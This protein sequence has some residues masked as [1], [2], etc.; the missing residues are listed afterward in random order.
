MLDL[1]QPRAARSKVLTMDK[2]IDL[3]LRARNI[4]PVDYRPSAA[5][6]RATMAEIVV[7]FLMRSLMPSAG[8]FPDNKTCCSKTCCSAVSRAR[9]SGAR[10][11]R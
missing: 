5:A 6:R 3:D 8:L 10:M 1:V 2:N 7:P 4:L 9:D 11:G